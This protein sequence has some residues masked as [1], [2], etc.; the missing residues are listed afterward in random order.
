VIRINCRP[1]SLVLAL[2]A[3]LV[4]AGCGSG[5]SRVNAAAIVGDQVIPLDDVQQ[6]IQWV[7]DNVPQAAKAQ[8]QRKFAQVSR[9]IVRSRVTHKLVTIAARREGLR[10]DHSKVD[11]LIAGSGGVDRIARGYAIEPQR[12]R[13]VARDQILLEQLGRRYADRL[14][15]DFVGTLI[16]EESAGSTAKDTARALGNRIAADP[17]RAAEIIRADG[18]QLMAKELSLAEAL[19]AQPELGISAVFGAQAGSVVVTQPS[20]RSS[21]WLVA[22]VRDRTVAPAHDGGAQ[23]PSQ[24]DPS[25]LPAV[26]MRQLQPI[27]DELGV[28]INPRYG[29]WDS[30]AMAPAASEDEVTGFQLPSRTVRS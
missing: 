28:R 9:E 6:E 10:V 22:L 26:G 19:R 11:E 18:H 23:G 12:V 24:V 17:S 13:T 29:V 5:P 15:V 1:V 7:L 16:V 8:Q 27:A 2:V 25:M 21:G 14:S 30:T 4:L 20:Q 3:S